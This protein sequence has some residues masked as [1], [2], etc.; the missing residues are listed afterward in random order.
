MGWPGLAR[1]DPDYMAAHL[2]N[3]VLGVFGMMGRLGESIREEQGLA[4]YCYSQL[5]AGL[6]QGPWAAVAGV[7]PVHVEQAVDS[8]CREVA[9]LR[10]EPVPAD[11]L[12]DSQSYLAGSMP[13]H[14]E[15][16]EGVAN[17]LLDMER[18]DLGFD[19]LQRYA[20]LVGAVTVDDVRRAAQK[21]LDPE[22]YALAVAGPAE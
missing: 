19:Y 8:V 12:A 17:A 15:T 14:L 3:T 16:N 18:Y 20:G 1:R 6:G 2:A 7:D 11:E 22:R 4:Y 10:D 9:R 13:L 5:Q 21:Y